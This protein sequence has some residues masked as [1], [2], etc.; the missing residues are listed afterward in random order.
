M[1]T[2]EVKISDFES[3]L[4]RRINHAEMETLLERVKGEV[5]EFIPEQDTAKLELN[6]SNR[7]D[8]WSPEGIARQIALAES[9]KEY[10]FFDP[11]RKAGRKVLVSKGVQ[12]VRPYVAAAV[13]RG[14]VVTD[15]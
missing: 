8:L 4:R 6:D 3:L 15:T 10:P 11:K 12:A 5:K 13:A 2:I 14:V 7:P 9:K 1:P